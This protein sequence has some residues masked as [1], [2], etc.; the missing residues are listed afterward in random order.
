MAFDLAPSKK[1]FSQIKANI[2][3][4]ALTSSFDVQIPVPPGDKFEGFL[5]DNGLNLDQTKLN[6]LCSE[7]TL[8]GS[9]LATLE[10]TGDFTGVTERHAYRRVYDDRID[11]TFYVNAE[12]YLP[13]H[14]FETW[15]KF[16]VDESVSKQKSKN[17]GSEAKN[18]FYAVRYPEEYISEGLTVRK[19]ERNLNSS[20][21][22]KFVSAYPVSLSSI[23]I[24]Y[25][26]SSLLKCTVSM[27]YIR[28]ILT[29]EIKKDEPKNQ[30]NSNLTSEQQSALQAAQKNGVNFG[31]ALSLDKL[32]D[33]YG[34]SG[35]TGGV[36]LTAVNSSG[37]TVQI[38]NFNFPSNNNLGTTQLGGPQQG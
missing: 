31:T 25:D 16:I 7:A 33:S 32:V 23:P 1:T 24:A 26:S 15:M 36:P 21:E 28:Y 6:F 11:L 14:F 20:L 34:F 3:N 9:N 2:L 17:V 4:P 37:N 22:Y 35:G 30:N 19:F 29:K 13:I 18:Y 5:K 38:Q 8:P 10:I 27:N 12:D